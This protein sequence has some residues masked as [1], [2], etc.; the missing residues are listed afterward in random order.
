MKAKVLAALKKA[1]NNYV[2]GEELSKTLQVSRTAIWKAV[3]VLRRQG[4]EI[5]SSPRLG[6]RLHEVDDVLTPLEISDGLK[7]K[8]LG[9]KIHFFAE[10]DSTNLVAQKLAAEGAPEGTVVLAKTQTSGK[11][12]LGRTWSS[13]PGGV[14]LSLILR[15]QLVPMQVPLITLVAAGSCCGGHCRGQ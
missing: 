5:E 2:S 12:R 9:K 1:K 11:G 7:T 14:W 8:I 15:P 3:N 10:V 6:Y 4:Y 13:P